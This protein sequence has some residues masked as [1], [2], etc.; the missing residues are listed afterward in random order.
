MSRVKVDITADKSG[1]ESAVKGV[2]HSIEGLKEMVVGAFSVEAVK[3]IVEK[4]FEYAET[5]DK[6][7]L[8]MKMTTE[9]TQALSIVAKEAG[10]SL[11]AVEGAFR[12]IEAA[13]AKALGGNAKAL[14]SFKALGVDTSQL[15]KPNNTLGLASSL[16]Q[17]ARNG[18][19]DTQGVALQGLGLK[20]TA[21]DLAAL[22]DGLTNFG[23]KV[24]ELKARGAIME[25]KDIAN[26]VRAKDELAIV[27]TTLMAQVAP[28]LSQLIEGLEEGWI[29]FS[30][31]AENT[32]AAIILMGEHAIEYI[33]SL[34]TSLIHA[35]ANAINGAKEGYA[36]GGVLGGIGG[37]VNGATKERDKANDTF[38]ANIKS[39]FDATL[40]NNGNDLTKRLNDYQSGI[41]K[42]LE[43]RAKA[44][45]NHDEPDA[46]FVAPKEKKGAKLYS[47]ALTSTGNMIGASFQGAGS[48][49]SA[50]DLARQQKAGI[51]SLNDKAD[52]QNDFLE[53]IA[54]NTGDDNDNEDS[55][56]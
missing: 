34:V 31:T 20:K 52:K 11:E 37:F 40:G 27:G 30:T 24:D 17:S 14:A 1:F 38:A 46:K 13:R 10:S 35:P 45:E 29:I 12:K 48:V 53:R 4:T 42:Q 54:D 16:A 9:Q 15:Q 44:R 5:I 19:N 39:D 41:A 32:F 56:P 49:V 43:A 23:E 7:S 25:D 2:E 8:R 22:G 3:G 26:I 50:I 47:D 6:A 36:K 21:G 18:S 33:K 51:D 55:W 28:W